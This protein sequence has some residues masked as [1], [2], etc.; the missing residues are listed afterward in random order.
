M[1]S[2][3]KKH[4][5]ID[6]VSITLNCDKATFIKKFRENVEHSDLSFRPFGPYLTGSKLYKGNIQ[7]STF[8]IMKTKQLFE[9]K[10]QSAI[11]NGK[12]TEDV[13]YIKV[14]IE[15]YGITSFMKFFIA[16]FILFEIIIFSVIS[17][18]LLSK[19]ENYDNK[20]LLVIVFHTFVF[21]CMFYF[22][23]RS[24]VKRFKQDIEREFHF[25]LK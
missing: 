2:L 20:I 4:K 7:D 5:L 25:W 3:L 13:N 9:N 11:G 8:K 22:L 17:F 6:S 23:A 14:D 12:I 21:L 15:I 10:K 24:L 16:M 1:D 19:I 18:K